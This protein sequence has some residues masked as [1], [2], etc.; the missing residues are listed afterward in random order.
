MDIDLRQW[1]NEVEQIGELKKVER[2]D[3]DGEI[4]CIAALNVKRKDGPALLF[5]RIEGYPS[6]YRLL[7]SSTLTPSR[8]ALTLNLPKRYS[9]LEL[10]GILQR[11]LREWDRNITSFPPELVE[12]GPV[13]ENVHWGDDVDLLEFPAPKWHELDGGRY[14]GTGDA[15][16]TRDP[17]TGEVNLGAYRV[18]V[19]DR[20]NAGLFV[21]PG[22]HGRV[23]YEKYHSKGKP[24]PI[25]VSLG[26]H[27]LVFRV[28][29]I[30][31]P[32]GAEYGYI[33]A[34]AESPVKVIKEEVTGL[35]IPAD[36]EVVIV[37][38]CPPG[39][40]MPEGPFGEWTGYYASKELPAPVIEVERVY[41]R[42]SP[43]ILGSQNDH[44]PS[45][46][47]YFMALILS[48]TLQNE[49][50]NSGIPD[51]KG[52]WYSSVAGRMLIIVSIKQRYA[53]H[54][55][56][57]ALFATQSRVAHSGRYVIVVDDDIDPTKIEDVLWAMCTRSDP[58]KDI[59]IIRRAWSSPIDPMIRKPAKAY[60][61]SRAIIDACKPYEWMDEFP[62]D[63]RISTE[64]VDR[65]KKKWK[66]LFF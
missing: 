35:P 20:K 44:P 40:K 14:I 61:N 26:H 12:T 28:A 11:K 6:G 65:V 1:L 32:P 23:H 29:C 15:V 53:G 2:A 22:H 52:V 13:M 17:D 55:K 42:N 8:I 27:P 62:Q 54:A 47:T 59:D 4:G 66:D 34:V 45:D 41:H 49:M 46:G 9:D 33:G 36:S 3:W 10:A 50:T 43:V 51:V 24:C 16:I 39:K 31:I 64:L 37:G 38:W 48:A 60:F 25:A 7:T 63:I 30:E 5:D 56:Q 58:E 21:V 18:Q 19:H 57:A